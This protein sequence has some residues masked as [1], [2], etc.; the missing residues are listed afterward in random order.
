MSAKNL[1]ARIGQ[2][3]TKG[4]HKERFLFVGTIKSKSSL[5][6]FFYLIE[7][8]T[9]WVDGEKIKNT[10][11]NTFGMSWQNTSND[12]VEI[13][14]SVIKKI[15]SELGN[16]SQN[17]EHEWIG[18]LNAIIGVSSENELIFSQTGRI[19]GYL[20]R[21]DKI[22]HITEKPLDTEETHPLKTFVS[23][24]NGNVAKGDKVVIANSMF[25]SHLSLDRLRQIFSSLNYK[26][27]IAEIAKILWRS[28]V[29]DVNL[30]FFDLVSSD[31][32][33][34]DST[35]GDNLIILD[36]IPDSKVLH[37][38]K[39][40]FKSTVKG[41]KAGGRGIK[42]LAEF[43]AKNIAPKV[44]NRAKVIGD[45]AKSFGGNA[46]K[47]VAE[48]FGNVPK[49][50]C[51]DSKKS[52]SRIKGFG[53]FFANLALWTK[54]LIQ[55]ENRKFLY[56]GLIVIFLLIGFIKIQ[57][58][59]GN[60]TNLKSQSENVNSL[61][62]ARALYAEALDDLGLKRD[63]GKEKLIEAKTAAEKA[64]ESPVIEEEAKNLLAQ[65]QSKL[66]KINLAIRISSKTEPSFSIAAENQIIYAIGADLYSFATDGNIAKF[67]TR[68]KTLDQVSKVNDE[69][70]KV[71]SIAFSDN[72]NSFFLLTEK[73]KVLMFDI[74]ASE[75]TEQKVTEI[76]GKWESAKSLAL[77]TTNIYLLDSEGGSIW[78][79]SKNDDGYSKGTSYLTKQP[80]SLKAAVDISI[81]GDVYVLKADGTVVK[82]KKSVEDTEYKIGEI[83]TPDSTIKTAEKINTSVDSNSIFIF[84]KGANR[85]L[86]FTK[87]GAYKRQFVADSEITLSGFS[88][89]SKLKKIW[90]VSGEKVFELDL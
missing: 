80:I 23:I 11:V 36:D 88:V 39:L 22:S 44:N 34:E 78:K 32:L 84:D 74:D 47:P 38:S 45:K 41:A 4:K 6:R 50:N 75:V 5:D 8:D 85:V 29:R 28:K 40:F 7:I 16:L 56:I 72:Q 87:T 46:V 2:I 69:F 52:G 35:V 68:K 33:E 43:W 12:K 55:A 31:E 90:L 48:R 62:S 37:Y 13:F 20:F 15:N 21:G 54:Q 26:E 76:E 19:S 65:I 63:G 57:L 64:K 17:G 58:N 61:D 25:Y 1:V 49:V 18:K 14:E 9:P 27:V 30:L 66:D 70:G 82:I 83:P 67:D 53:R 81:D 89:N 60:N 24:I 77:F 73:T 79:H 3:A 71:T 42:K 59:S 51:F 86:E 10:I